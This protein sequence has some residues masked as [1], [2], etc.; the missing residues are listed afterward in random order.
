MIAKRQQGLKSVTDEW[1]VLEN[2]SARCK[3]TAWYLF[4][5]SSAD[6]YSQILHCPFA[7]M[8]CIVIVLYKKTTW[9]RIY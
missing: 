2:S 6:K 3:A 9:S 4:T 5:T 7:A 1:F 8:N